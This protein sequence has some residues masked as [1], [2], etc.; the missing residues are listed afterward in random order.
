M[1]RQKITKALTSFTEPP[2]SNPKR[3][4]EGKSISYIT[5]NRSGAHP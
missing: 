1:T 2:I 4:D 3:P 5:H